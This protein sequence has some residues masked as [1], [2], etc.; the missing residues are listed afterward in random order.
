MV[1]RCKRTKIVV[2]HRW[3]FCC[4]K[5]IGHQTGHVFEFSSGRNRKTEDESSKR[6]IFSSLLPRFMLY[7][8]SV[9][10][11]QKSERALGTKIWKNIV[12]NLGIPWYTG[13][14]TETWRWPVKARQLQQ[15]PVPQNPVTKAETNPTQLQTNASNGFVTKTLST[16]CPPFTSFALPALPVALLR[17]DQAKRELAEPQ[18]ASLTESL[19]ESGKNS[20]FLWLTDLTASWVT[21]SLNIFELFSRHCGPADSAFQ[22]Q[23][24]QKQQASQLNEQLRERQRELIKEQELRSKAEE[25][26]ESQAEETSANLT[27][28]S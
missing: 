6:P 23:S 17:L 4:S 18:K 25:T 11:I 28:K 27:F 22:V 21:A 16:C 9:D 1:K 12:L 19:V 14:C 5:N 26:T 15:Q 7:T 24:E 2:D 20:S 13:T 3:F 10:C 8:V